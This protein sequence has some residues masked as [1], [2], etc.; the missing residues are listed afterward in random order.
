MFDG[1]GR[2]GGQGLTGTQISSYSR[3]RG[4]L[5]QCRC[6]KPGLFVVGMG[7]Q[8]F[9]RERGGWVR[10]FTDPGASLGSMVGR[11]AKGSVVGDWGG[12]KGVTG[13]NI[14]RNL[15]ELEGSLWTIVGSKKTLPLCQGLAYGPVKQKKGPLFST[16]R[17]RKHPIPN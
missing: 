5:D 14:S 13:T 12:V 3:R 2:R 10:W 4:S 15:L 8:R 1:F 7:A 17:Q 9:M 6:Q 16:T 11:G